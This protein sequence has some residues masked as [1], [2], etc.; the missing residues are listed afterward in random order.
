MSPER[1][2]DEALCIERHGDACVQGLESLPEGDRYTWP[3]GGG[4]D[5]SVGGGGGGGG[6]VVVVVG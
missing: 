2:T 6:G 4:G 5:V 1:A 3:L